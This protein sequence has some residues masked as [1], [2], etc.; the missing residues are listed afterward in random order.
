M[1]DVKLNDSA[2]NDAELIKWLTTGG[3]TLTLWGDTGDGK[4]AS[5]GELAEFLY[6]NGRTA[7]NKPLKTRLYTADEGGTETI[8]HIIDAGIIE[9]VYLARKPR[10]W[11]WINHAT[12]GE[13]LDSNDKWVKV[14]NSQIGQFV[15]EGMGSFGEA[16]RTGISGTSGKMDNMP[17]MTADKDAHGRSYGLSQD[18]LAEAI[19]QSFML[20]GIK[21]W[22]ARSR[23]GEEDN[24][25]PILGPQVVGKAL[26]NEVP[27][28]FNYTF[29]IT[30]IPT[31]TLLKIKETH[32]LFLG[33]HKDGVQ[34][35][36][37]NSRNPLIGLELPPFVEPA[38]LVEGFRWILKSKIYAAQLLKDRISKLNIN[39]TPIK[40]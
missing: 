2:I 15:W 7:D 4:T 21:T 23:R 12:L 6:M 26:T 5:I 19:K 30:A 13:V 24:N 34:K 1:I 3:K 17:S 20:P 22:T 39:V 28:W 11:E 14:D 10:P 27:S 8:S 29:R 36:L 9:A 38:S 40:A 25:T 35:G 18:R 37:G 33:D 31:D 16:L 32:R